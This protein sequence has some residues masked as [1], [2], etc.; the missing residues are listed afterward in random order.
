MEEERGRGEG[1]EGGEERRVGGKGGE[2][3]ESEGRGGEDDSV[4]RCVC[5]FACVCCLCVCVCVTCVFV[6]MHVHVCTCY[7]APFHGDLFCVHWLQEVDDFSAGL[8]QGVQILCVVLNQLSQG[9]KGLP[10]V[11]VIIVLCALDADVYNVN[12]PSTEKGTGGK[13]VG[14]R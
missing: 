12:S 10:T 4:N 13:A 2:E 14:R 7:Y 11:E 1:E 9:R 8:L 3:E 5:L 6:C